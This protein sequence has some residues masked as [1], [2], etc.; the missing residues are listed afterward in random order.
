MSNKP[1][2][3]IT[4]DIIDNITMLVANCFSEDEKEY[5]DAA[6]KGVIE[7]LYDKYDH[8]REQELHHGQH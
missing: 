2:Y 3:A 4:A 7:P 8:E 1:D 5:I 6:Y